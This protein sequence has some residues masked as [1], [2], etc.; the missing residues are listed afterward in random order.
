MLCSNG[1]IH[2]LDSV[3]LPSAQT[4]VEVAEHAG[5]FKTLLAAL[6]AADL[7][8]VLGG[9]GPFTV[10]APSDEAFTKLPEGTVEALVLPENRAKLVALLQNHVVA[11]R[12][13]ADQVVALERVETLG[14]AHLAVSSSAAGVSLAGARVAKADI[15]ARNGVIHVIDTVIV[16][17]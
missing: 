12:V 14:G 15:E 17:Q 8:K 13:Y 16:L 4:V 3:L 5:S 9:A 11:G 6:D 10:L 7:R 1:V 2:V